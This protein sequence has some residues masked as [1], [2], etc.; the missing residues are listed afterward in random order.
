MHIIELPKFEINFDD[1]LN[2][3]ISFL[4]DPYNKYFCRQGTDKIFKKA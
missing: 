2:T 1:P 3:W 4:K